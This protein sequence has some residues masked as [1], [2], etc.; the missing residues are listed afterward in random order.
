MMPAAKVAQDVA[1][2]YPRLSVATHGHVG[3]VDV[4][5]PGLIAT[6]NALEDAV[7]GTLLI[8]L[9]VSTAVGWPRS[10]VEQLAERLATLE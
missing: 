5:Q 6:A 8:L 3:A 7:T 4:W 9:W 10:D 1:I 2:G